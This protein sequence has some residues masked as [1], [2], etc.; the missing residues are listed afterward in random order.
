MQVTPLIKEI[1]N[2]IAIFPEEK[3]K[4]L[5]KELKRQ[6]LIMQARKLDKE[7]RKN[8]ITHQEIV[9]EVRIVR[10]LLYAKK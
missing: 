7:I 10:K 5:L 6:A 3:Q 8:E 2:I 9:E 4:A 1:Q